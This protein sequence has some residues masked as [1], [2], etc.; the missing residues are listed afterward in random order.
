M[1]GTRIH[2]YDLARGI[3]A[4]IMLVIHFN[5]LLLS[6]SGIPEWTEWMSGLIERRSA[7]LLVLLSGAG[8][9]LFAKTMARSR[10]RQAL[11]RRSVFLF[12]SG[13]LLSTVWAGEILCFYCIYTLIGIT[14][15]QVSTRKLITTGIVF[16]AGGIIQ[17]MDPETLS[18]AVADTHPA[19]VKTVD[20]LVTGYFPLFP[21]MGFFIA[22]MLLG[23]VNIQ[24][25]KIQARIMKWGI[26]LLVISGGISKGVEYLS[27]VLQ[28]TVSGGTA[29]LLADL[30]MITRIELTSCTPFS[31]F[32]GVGSALILITA[33]LRLAKK[34]GGKTIQCFFIAGRTTLTFY[35][36]HVLLIVFFYTSPIHG[37]FKR[38]EPVILL[39]VIYFLI[40]GRIMGYW[41]KSH[42]N[43][44][45]EII[46]RRFVS[47]RIPFPGEQIPAP[48]P[49][50]APRRRTVSGKALS[51]FFH[52]S[53]SAIFSSF[54][55]YDRISRSNMRLTN[56]AESV[57]SVFN[58]GASVSENQSALNLNDISILVV[59]DMKSMR[60]TI[61]KM[62]QNLNIGGKLRFAENGKQGLEVLKKDRF[63]LAIVDWNM[64]V[65]NGITMLG[66]IRKD[67]ALREMAVI[68]V[69]AEAERD[70]VSEVA[71]T[72]IDGYLLKPLT[73]EAL[74]RKIKTAIDRLNNPDPVTLHRNKARTLEEKGEYL[75]AIEEIKKALK[76]KPSASRLLRQLGL[77]HFKIQKNAIAEK[78]LLKAVSV[79]DQDTISRVHL[80]DYYLKKN[81]LQKT[82]RY[83]IEILTLSNRYNDKAFDIGERLL[84]TGDRD[85]ALRIFSKV[86]IQSRKQGAVRDQI[87]DI[88]L[89][90]GK[91]NSP[92]SCLNGPSKKTRPTMT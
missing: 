10:I 81:D 31:F 83:Y 76:H 37:M 30:E 79:N 1:G 70:I 73:L 92:W 40:Y 53:G 34:T 62:L 66:E 7:T 32:S 5:E 17:Y 38:M 8:I 91:L 39:S 51:A 49:L 25:P 44:P 16:W 75:E 20:L 68:M 48:P 82:G 24:A 64:P 21:W 50:T 88:C 67:P 45:L 27:M 14:L 80:A 41:L 4:L 54:Y 26:L 52:N 63:D 85:M 90:H 18:W 3:A 89:S 29:I 23:R 65:M 6:G 69:T 78:C 19:L 87:I 9:T 57:F 46:L 2:G 11:V 74:D 28:G 71:E 12:F 43:G 22:G 33:A 35:I 61:R 47:F 55:I 15:L 13:L 56:T 84:Q 86:L 36:T 42:S 77:L 58:K 59:D 60:L 72:E